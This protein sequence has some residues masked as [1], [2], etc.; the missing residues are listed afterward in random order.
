MF[1]TTQLLDV[2]VSTMVIRDHQTVFGDH[3]SRAA[4]EIQGHDGIL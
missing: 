2:V 3:A 4:S 1:K